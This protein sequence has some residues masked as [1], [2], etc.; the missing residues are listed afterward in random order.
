[1]KKFRPV[2][3]TF[4]YKSNTCQPA[5]LRVTLLSHLQKHTL[6]QLLYLARPGNKNPLDRKSTVELAALFLLVPFHLLVWLLMFLFLGASCQS[7]S[8]DWWL[9]KTW[10]SLSTSHW[11]DRFRLEACGMN[12]RCW[13][14]PASH[15]NLRSTPCSSVPVND[16]TIWIE[17]FAYPTVWYLWMKIESNLHGIW[18]IKLTLYL[19]HFEGRKYVCWH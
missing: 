6:L 11:S 2:W 16:F 4:K 14:I 3:G 19:L 13:E 5:G 1:M 12:L 17:K 9:D 8:A 18:N 15:G 10:P 7:N